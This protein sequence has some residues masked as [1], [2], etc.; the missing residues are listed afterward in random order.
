MNNRIRVQRLTQD[1]MEDVLEI[2]FTEKIA[3]AA[4]ITYNPAWDSQ[5]KVQ[6]QIQR[7]GRLSKNS[8]KSAAESGASA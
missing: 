4:K 7:T 1:N 2:P 8:A 3:T 5:A 6:Q